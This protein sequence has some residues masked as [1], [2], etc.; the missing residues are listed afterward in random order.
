MK[1]ASLSMIKAALNKMVL[2]NSKIIYLSKYCGEA[3]NYHGEEIQGLTA[4][5]RKVGFVDTLGGASLRIVEGIQ[6]VSS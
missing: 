1:E 5:D 3:K 2:H 4:L 6:Y